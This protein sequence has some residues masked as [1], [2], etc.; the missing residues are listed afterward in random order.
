MTRWG[1]VLVLALACDAAPPPGVPMGTWSATVTPV[2]YACGLSDVS[3]E[4]FS[5]DLVLTHDTSSEEAWVTLNGYSRAA[6]FDGQHLVSSAEAARIF[7]QCAGCRT[8][9]SEAMRFT[10]FSRSQWEATGACRF[11]GTVPDGEGITLP[12]RAAQG[13]DAVRLCGAMEVAVRSEGTEDGGACD[14]VCD[15]CLVR[16][17]LEGTRR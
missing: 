4:G 14:A 3:P 11:D 10:V 17:Q 5:F 16:Y 8:R 6:T 12:G 1:W 13:F 2:E 9:M 15:G 7:T